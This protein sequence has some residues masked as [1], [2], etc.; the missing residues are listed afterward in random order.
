MSCTSFQVV[1]L[2]LEIKLCCKTQNAYV[3]RESENIKKPTDKII[4]FSH[5]HHGNY[6][7]ILCMEDTL[8]NII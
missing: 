8:I 6:R 4:L 3:G 7:D 1:K 5:S 2:P